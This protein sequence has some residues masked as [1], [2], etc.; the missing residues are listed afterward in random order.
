VAIARHFPSSLVQRLAGSLSQDA[1]AESAI[2]SYVHWNPAIRWLMF[3]RLDVICQM[4]LAALSA[5]GGSNRA[6]LDYG[7]GIGMMVPVLAPSVTTLYLCDEQIAPAQETAK[8]FGTGNSVALVPG[9]LRH[10]VAD[11][12]LDVIIAADV[13]EHVDDLRPLLQLLSCKL[14]PDGV[15]I[16]SGPAENWAY[17][18][19]RWIAGFSGHYHVRNVY[20]VEAEVRQLDFIC[21]RVI[22]LPVL[23]TLFRISEWHR[24]RSAEGKS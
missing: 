5:R 14:R 7:C 11:A 6:V 23:P 13:L 22:R 21:R 16:V 1:K 18:F 8:W 17:R 12:G 4:V 10:R 24:G 9:E 3:R 20:D 15:L 2:P 19:G